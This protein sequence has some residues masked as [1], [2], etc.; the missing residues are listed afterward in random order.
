MQAKNISDKT[1]LE[2]LAAH[3][4]QWSF[5]ND[6]TLSFPN[7]GHKE[8]EIVPVGFPLKILHAKFKKLM[9]RGFIGGCACGCRGDFEITDKGLEFIGQ[10][11]TKPYTGY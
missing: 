9:K 2:L 4:G 5:W 8:Y 3:Q 10:I 1:I 6:N 11:R 7:E